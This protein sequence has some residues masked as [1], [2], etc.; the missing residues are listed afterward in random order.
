M[1][2]LNRV[3]LLQQH[4]P[5]RVHRED[6]AFPEEAKAELL[7]IIWRGNAIREH[8]NNIDAAG[9]RMHLEKGNESLPLL[10]FHEVKTPVRCDHVEGVRKA[11]G[12][13]VCDL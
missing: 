2:I 6:L 1:L 5:I 4:F 9:V 12:A 7:Q 10:P 3:A 8:D 13:H 11:I